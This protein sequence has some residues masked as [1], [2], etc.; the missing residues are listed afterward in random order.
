MTKYYKEP[1]ELFAR[2]VEGL[3]TDKE[4]VISLAPYTYNKFKEL[5][6]Q[7]YYSPLNKLFEI[8]NIIL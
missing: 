4:E 8:V 5:F 6:L 3:Y 1:T 7:G 2:F